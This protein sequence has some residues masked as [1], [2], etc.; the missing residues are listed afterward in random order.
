MNT[1]LGDDAAVSIEF[2]EKVVKAYREKYI[3]I[4]QLW[5]QYEE[6]AVTAIE[7]QLKFT[8]GAEVG[9]VTFFTDEKDFL[10]CRLPSGRLLRYHKPRIELCDYGYGRRKQI[11]YRGIGTSCKKYTTRSTYGGSL[12]ESVCQGVSRDLMANAA[13]NITNHRYKIITT[14]HDEIVAEK[15]IGTG[16]LE[17]YTLLAEKTPKWAEGCPVAAN[18]WTGA[19]YKK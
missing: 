4:W 1:A 16:S 14:I 17:E 2:C 9:A 11:T 3:K 18:G 10:C 6:A 15:E 8:N 5:S 7:Y 13:L 12:V 19:R